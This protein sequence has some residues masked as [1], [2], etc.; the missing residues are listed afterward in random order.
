MDAHSG[1]Q[2]ARKVPDLIRVARTTG[3]AFGEVAGLPRTHDRVECSTGSAEQVVHG[4]LAGYVELDAYLTDQG[5][6]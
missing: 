1:V 5:I 3:S 2:E 6:R 4:V